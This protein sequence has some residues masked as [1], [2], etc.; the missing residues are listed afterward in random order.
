MLLLPVRYFVILQHPF[1][2]F[3]DLLIGIQS[4]V[5]IDNTAII[6]WIHTM[7]KE[8]AWK[9]RHNPYHQQICWGRSGGGGEN[10]IPH[11]SNINKERKDRIIK[12]HWT[13]KWNEPKTFRSQQPP[14]KAFHR[15]KRK[16]ILFKSPT[17]ALLTPRC[18]PFQDYIP[19]YLTSLN[20]NCSFAPLSSYVVA[21]VN[22]SSRI[23]Y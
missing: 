2:Y 6:D 17:P 5:K 13:L 3:M 19:H 11:I 14:Q 21:T 16:K 15:S 9:L 22:I 18:L 7:W 23:G 4:L 20:P 1:I 10:P 12:E 8:T